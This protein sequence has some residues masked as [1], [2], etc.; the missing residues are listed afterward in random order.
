M[1]YSK[2]GT[3]SK[4]RNTWGVF[5]KKKKIEIEIGS[6]TD[7][8]EWARDNGWSAENDEIHVGW[9]EEAK[10]GAAKAKKEEADAAARAFES[11]MNPDSV[12]R[13][14]R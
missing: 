14:R 8:Y 13:R 7:F 10:A 3:K 9:R 11:L 6:F 1:D 5:K 4:R 12:S 2:V